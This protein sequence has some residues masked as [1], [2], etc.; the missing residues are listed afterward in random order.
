[1]I[2]KVEKLKFFP[3]RSRVRK[4]KNESTGGREKRTKKKKVAR[5]GRK[6]RVRYQKEKTGVVKFD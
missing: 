3:V 4:T 1:M 6:L 5:S 2:L